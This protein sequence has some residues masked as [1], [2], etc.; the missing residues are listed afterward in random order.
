M[1]TVQ[2]YKLFANKK[3][4]CKLFE[5][6]L[7]T[8]LKPTDFTSL[9]YNK[10]L[11]AF[12]ATKKFDN[13]VTQIS[14]DLS[15]SKGTV[16]SYLNG[17]IKAS[18]NFLEKFANFYNIALSEIQ[19]SDFEH[20]VTMLINDEVEETWTNKNG[21]KFLIYPDDSI[22]IEVAVLPFKAYA[23][24]EIECYFDENY[25]NREFS[26]IR[27]SVDKIGKGNYLGF[28]SENESMN[29]GGIN[30]TP[31]GAEIL[32]REIGKHLWQN[33]HKNDYGFILM[34]VSNVCHKDIVNYNPETGMFTLHSRNPTEKDFEV[35]IN[36][37]YR[38][39]NVIKRT[40]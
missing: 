16:S 34:T 13:A 20:E 33:L 9:M 27:F 5:N 29:G 21:I 17:K 32:G 37:V 15:V 38:I 28:I 2:I 25:T 3:T 24:S 22:K 18:K 19:D 35:S 10:K 8:F 30:D 1:C 11:I 23:S 6:N 7:Q 12:V 39:F 31:G 36:D 26:K 40:F 14:L 4:F